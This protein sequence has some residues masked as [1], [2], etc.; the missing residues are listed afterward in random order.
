MRTFAGEPNKERSVYREAVYATGGVAAATMALTANAPIVAAAAAVG[1]SIPMAHR[2]WQ[3]YQH[4]HDWPRP[5]EAPAGGDL[6]MWI[7]RAE[8]GRRAWFLLEHGPHMLVGGET[9]GGKSAFLRQALTGLIEWR[10]P[11]RVGLL[12]I[13]LKR[14]EFGYL[15]G[16]PHVLAVAK[17]PSEAAKMLDA[18]VAAVRARL[19]MI[20]A[21]GVNDVALLPLPVGRMVVVIDELA[22]LQDSKDCLAA[23]ETVARLGRAAGVHLVLC[24]QRPDKRALPGSIKANVPAV[25]AFRCVNGVNSRILLD[26]DSA[27]EIPTRPGAAV[28]RWRTTQTVQAPWLSLHDAE[29]RV[30]AR[31]G[32]SAVTA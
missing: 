20:E 10:D 15:S 30:K 24:T 32:L 19:R 28:W 12:I 5:D 11:R 31:G 17:E 14:V 4:R 13:D 3:A 7:G 6:P 23:I 25:L 22:E 27:C 18:A 8:T 29:G 21:A 2:I 16:A 26:D 9:G 1:G